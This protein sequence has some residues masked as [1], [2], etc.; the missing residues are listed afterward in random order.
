MMLRKK[1]LLII[2]ATLVGLLGFLYFFSRTV[3][4]RSFSQLEEQDARQNLDRSMSALSDELSSLGRTTRDYSSWDNTYAFVQGK[5]PDYAKTEFS[6][7]ALLNLRLNVVIVVDDSNHF[8]FKR[9]FDLDS[10]QPIPLTKNLDPIISTLQRNVGANGVV[11][12]P[13]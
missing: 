13:E 2:C 7:A 9:G 8:I 3:I 4:L 11:I 5:R 12:L 6:D 10:G 1:T